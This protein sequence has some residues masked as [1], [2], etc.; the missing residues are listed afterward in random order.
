MRV[1]LNELLF[2]VQLVLEGMHSRHFE[3]HN[4]FKLYHLVRLPN[5]CVAL[6]SWV[7][8]GNCPAIRE[9]MWKGLVRTVQKEAERAVISIANLWHFFLCVCVCC[10]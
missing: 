10:M 9:I 6:G 7:C 3:G 8:V 1:W 5:G 4:T 2:W